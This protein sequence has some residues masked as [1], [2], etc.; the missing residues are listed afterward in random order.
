[1]G[2]PNMETAK[3]VRDRAMMELLYATGIRVSELTHLLTGDVNLQLGYIVCRDKERERAIP[4]GDEAREVLQRYLGRERMRF[5]GESSCPYL[6][7]NCAGKPMSR[8]GFW[9]VLKGYAQAA[10]I[11]MDITPHTLRHSF[12]AHLIQNGADVKA[13]QEMMGHADIST[14]Q[15]YVHMNIN[16]IRSAYESAHPRSR[17]GMEVVRE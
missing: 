5:V 2:Q 1:M 8:Q 15:M 14:T 3:G 6:F 17:T 7:T 12:A 13:V 9:K 10:G 4:F 11:Q 16:R